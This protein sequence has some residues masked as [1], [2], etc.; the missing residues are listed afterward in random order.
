MFGVLGTAT[1]L[2]LPS[3]LGIVRSP[4]GRSMTDRPDKTP[5]RVTRVGIPIDALEYQRGVTDAEADIAAKSYR[6][7]WQTR[8]AWGDFFTELMQQRFAVHVVHT[9]DMTTYEELSHQSGYNDAVV[10]H[11][12][13]QF[14]A[15]SFQR[16]CDEVKA[17]REAGYRRWR[18]SEAKRL[19][20]G[21]KGEE[22]GAG[23]ISSG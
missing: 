4:K 6:L 21:P 2:E 19:D 11:L 22:D 14:G 17:Y 15:G 13:N 12:D 7:F 16:A 1:A 10:A 20:S 9:S 8:G 3:E 18:E 23:L 5:S